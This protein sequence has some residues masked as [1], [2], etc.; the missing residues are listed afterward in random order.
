M[1][2]FPRILIRRENKIVVNRVDKNFMVV[3]NGADAREQSSIEEWKKT[4]FKS[5]LNTNSNEGIYR[6][7]KRE[8]I[9][10]DYFS[11]N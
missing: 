2:L 11:K 6:C 5:P 9:F 10:E 4:F 1:S 8:K 3:I 7:S